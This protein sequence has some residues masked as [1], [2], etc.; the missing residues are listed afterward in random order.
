MARV[1]VHGVDLHAWPGAPYAPFAFSGGRSTTIRMQ[2]RPLLYGL[3]LF[4]EGTGHGSR[5][6]HTGVAT[7]TGVRAWATL[8]RTRGVRVV[9]VNPGAEAVQVSVALGPSARRPAALRLLRA[10]GLGARGQLS[11][12]GRAFGPDGGLHG[13]DHAT[14]VLPV[15]GSYALSLPSA[16]GGLLTLAPATHARLPASRPSRRFK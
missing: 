9:M 8:S 16:S 11:F 5:M 10:P 4:A 6:L 15:A 2:A 12:G 14:R 1:G 13:H 7:N 3:L